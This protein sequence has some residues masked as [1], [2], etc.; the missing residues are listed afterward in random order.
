V[1]ENMSGEV[2]GALA[3][4]GIRMAQLCFLTDPALML[5]LG[6]AAMIYPWETNMQ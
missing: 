3:A 2:R 6:I 4:A 1:I 5:P